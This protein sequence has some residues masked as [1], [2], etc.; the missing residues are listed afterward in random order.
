MPWL[1]TTS[2]SK[3]E[4]GEIKGDFGRREGITPNEY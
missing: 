2:L 1:L 4:E 3:Q